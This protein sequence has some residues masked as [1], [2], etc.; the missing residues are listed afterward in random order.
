M[1]YNDTDVKVVLTQFKISNKFLYKDPLPF[2]LQ[3]FIANKFI[4]ANCK[5]CYVGENTRHF[6]SRIS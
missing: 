3:S 6:I 5:V 1:F 2:Y 4:C